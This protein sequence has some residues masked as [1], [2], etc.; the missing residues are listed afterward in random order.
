MIRRWITGAIPTCD[1]DRLGRPDTE[2]INR[3]GYLDR[4]N[5]YVSYAIDL[6][7]GSADS[8]YVE[9]GDIDPAKWGETDS[10]RLY[11]I[12]LTDVVETVGTPDLSLVESIRLWVTGS[13]DSTVY[14]ISIA[15]IQVVGNQWREK[16][17]EQ[18]GVTLPP[19]TVRVTVR[20]T[21]ENA[22]VY[23]PPPGV[24][25]VRDRV[26][27]L[28]QQ[29][30]SLAL[31]FS[32]L[33]PGVEGEAFRNIA[34]AENFTLYQGLGMFLNGQPAGSWVA[35]TDTSYI[36]AFIRFG[37]DENNF[38]EYRAPVYPGWDDRNDVDVIFDDI[39]ALKVALL[40][41]WAGNPGVPDTTVG[42]Y[43]IRGRP[44]ITNIRRLSIGVRNLHPSLAIDGEIWA[45]ELRV[46]DVRRD[47]GTASR[48]AI[49]AQLADV[50][51]VDF[52]MDYR[53]ADFHGLRD[54]RGTLSTTTATTFSVRT[55]LD[56]FTPV[57][58]G[59]LM[60]LTINIR[61]NLRLPKYLPGS[62]LI[63]AESQRDQHQT[64]LEDES[65]SLQ[66]RK[67]T[68]SENK[69]VAWTLDRMTGSFT[70]SRR[71]GVS[72]V[73]PINES[74]QIQG[75]F[76]YDLSPRTTAEW[77]PFK[78]LFFLP[79]S[80]KETAFNPIPTQL[81]YNLVALQNGEKVADRS[82]NVRHR[83]AFTATESYNLAMQ[84]FASMRS[85][86]SLTYNR[87]LTEDWSFGDTNLGK[88][89]GRRQV[90]DTSW[91]PGT[92]SW[93]SQRYQYR[94]EYRENNDP[95]FN[96]RIQQ[97]PEG[98]EEIE[99]G[100]D[101]VANVDAS[102][103]YTVLP[104]RVVGAPRPDDNLKGWAR[105][106]NDLKKLVAR[107]TPMIL[108]ISQD[109]TG[110][111]FNL[112]GRPSL[113]YRFGLKETPDVGQTATAATQQ[114]LIRTT[115]RVTLNSGYDLPLSAA[116]DI[117]PRW[118]WIDN[119]SESQTTYSQLITWPSMTFRWAGLQS[120]WIFPNLTRALNLTSSFNKTSE[121]TERLSDI[122]FG[123]REPYSTR[124]ITAWQPLAGLQAT[125]NNG[126]GISFNRN[127][128]EI[129]LEQFTQS[130]S[131][132][133]SVNS[134]FR[135]N[136][137]YS[138]SAPQG[139]KIPFFKNPLR[140]TSTL[141]MSL[142]LARSERITEVKI[143]RGQSI[144][145][146]TGFVPTLSN[147]TWSIRPTMRYNFSRMVQ[148]GLDMLFENVNDRLME[149]NRKVR[150]VAIFINLFF[151]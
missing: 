38:Y 12:P 114:S 150:E 71:N 135:L 96:T 72:P 136:I 79:R 5:H 31:T 4:S 59:L 118:T 8:I 18:G 108:D 28:A 44:S 149:R 20:N 85:T 47:R 90:F 147:A 41:E 6:T 100:R 57:R 22:G 143:G 67:A 97:T 7:P 73:N 107:F 14:Q 70:A 151:S 61:R 29:E 54:K 106:T 98:P 68:P 110:N 36:E 81:M 13:P 58:W 15:S 130:R 138:F 105:L 115:R 3:N 23:T 45:D 104:S 52:R 102:A 64:S 128:A 95:R 63:L 127:Y 148:G 27:N 132:T 43:R 65:I 121:Q 69:I 137:S 112:A 19:E 17:V 120:L 103:N 42:N 134:D 25:L 37:A 144:T 16:P 56:K 39:T 40:E 50:T 24:R 142:D 89:I 66:F 33:P 109:R 140:F 84:P 62:D 131:L 77:H 111:Q 92:F 76:G 49:R 86:Y 119:L 116:L 32:Q 34:R 21:F 26:T 129:G 87:D 30:Q 51:T 146:Q 123:V 46:L 125:L 9:G 75:Q 141:D 124:K 101:V 82:L 48:V 78:L 11:R 60:P 74:F 53:T 145:G 93:L 122:D 94:A 35:S 1:P 126:I 80:L 117:S 83:F 2:D 88:E 10:W 113:G 99:L 55:A 133:R 139:I 91:E